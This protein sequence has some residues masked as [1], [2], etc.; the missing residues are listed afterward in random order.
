MLDSCNK[1]E[2]IMGK[3]FLPEGTKGV[4]PVLNKRKK[5]TV[6]ITSSTKNSA[7]VY[8][9]GLASGYKTAGIIILTI[10]VSIGLSMLV[11][12]VV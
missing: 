3:T 12:G 9:D 10:F 7:H 8:E 2:D 4:K 1:K 5:N 11:R 6:K